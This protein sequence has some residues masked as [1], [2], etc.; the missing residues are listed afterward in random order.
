MGSG[1][2]GNK[3]REQQETWRNTLDGSQFKTGCSSSDSTSYAGEVEA[4]VAKPGL[5]SEACYGL[6]ESVASYSPLKDGNFPAH[7]HSLLLLLAAPA[8][9][10]RDH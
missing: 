7:T 6:A 8:Q 3:R 2:V 9:R 5:T 4:D 1:I 10:S